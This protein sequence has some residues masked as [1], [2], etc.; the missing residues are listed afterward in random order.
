MNN[1]PAEIRM[2]PVIDFQV[3]CSCKKTKARIDVRAA[4]T[5][6]QIANNN[7]IIFHP[8]EYCIALETEGLDRGFIVKSNRIPV[9]TLALNCR[10]IFPSAS[11]TDESSGIKSGFGRK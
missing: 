11:I 6:E 9:E 8:Y 1:V 10:Q 5:A 4:N 2:Q 3:N 7:H